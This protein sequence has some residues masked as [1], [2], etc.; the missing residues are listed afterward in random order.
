MS[1][2][3]KELI[4][5]GEYEEDSHKKYDK[6]KEAKRHAREFL[7][8]AS[9]ILSHNKKEGSTDEVTKL[10][11][12]LAKDYHEAIMDAIQHERYT[13]RETSEPYDEEGVDIDMEPH[14]YGSVGSS[15]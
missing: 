4:E 15:Y 9:E 13:G 7:D 10:A 6:E 2:F 5:M 8:K 14:G 12:Q 1:S 3:I 11:L